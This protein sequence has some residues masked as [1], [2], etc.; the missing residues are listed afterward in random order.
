MRCQNFKAKGRREKNKVEAKTKAYESICVQNYVTWQV[1][2]QLRKGKIFFD[3]ANSVD[4]RASEEE[5]D[6]EVSN[7]EYTI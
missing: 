4:Q 5:L 7:F 3:H 2:F 1:F 6:T